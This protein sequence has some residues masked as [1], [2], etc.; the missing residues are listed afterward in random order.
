MH[1]SRRGS[2]AAHPTVRAEN[3]CARPA[4]SRHRRTSSGRTR[5]LS[6][7]GKESLQITHDPKR[8]LRLSAASSPSPFFSTKKP[9]Q[10]PTIGYWNISKVSLRIRNSPCAQREC[11]R[12]SR[13]CWF[14]SIRQSGF[15]CQTVCEDTL[16]IPGCVINPLV[17][18]TFPPPSVSLL[19]FS[20]SSLRLLFS[21]PPP[22]THH[23]RVQIPYRMQAVPSPVGV[24][25][26]G[27]R[28]AAGS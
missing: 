2:R 20:L 23:F 28:S 8:T 3:F 14:I 5:I 16:R 4:H 19:T 17:S 15:V 13:S 25:L 18:L 10:K 1:G 11:E 6:Q 9:K 7:R 12:R 26:E 22:S 24:G 21:T 27:L